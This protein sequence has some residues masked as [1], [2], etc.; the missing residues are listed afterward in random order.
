MPFP[1]NQNRLCGQILRLLPDAPPC[2]L[3]ACDPGIPCRY[4]KALN[5]TASP[6]ILIF[7]EPFSVKWK[8]IK[9]RSR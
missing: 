9:H 1:I 5:S 7:A 2:N 6:T 4:F 8:K 3:D